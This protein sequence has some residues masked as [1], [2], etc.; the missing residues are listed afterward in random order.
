V[1]LEELGKVKTN[2]M[3]SSEF[4]P[5]TFWFA[6]QLLDPL[7]YLLVLSIVSR[8]SALKIFKPTWT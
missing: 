8:A 2:A 5:V 3:A 7:C 4:E 6:A 1:R